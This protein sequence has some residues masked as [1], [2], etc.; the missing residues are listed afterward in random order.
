MLK[1]K[2]S[3]DLNELKKF[4]FVKVKKGMTDFAPCVKW[5]FSLDGYDEYECLTVFK[6]RTL[7]PGLE[8]NGKSTVL[9]TL[10]DLIKADLVE[11]V[12]N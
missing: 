4:G 12:E 2:N 9:D 10:Y 1:I 3:I 5:W 6:D 11:K 8:A 7:Y